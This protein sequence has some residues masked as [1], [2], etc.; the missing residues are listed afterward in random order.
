MSKI[1][2]LQIK[3]DQSTTIKTISYGQIQ[4]IKQDP[5]R[6]IVYIN[7]IKERSV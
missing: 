1:V 5:K 2:H 6:P 7:K 4:A 3:A